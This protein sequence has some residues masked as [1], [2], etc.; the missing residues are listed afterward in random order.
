MSRLMPRALA[1]VL[2]TFIPVLSALLLGIASAAAH[3]HLTRAEPSVDSTVASPP[4]ELTLWFTENLES[5]FSSIEVTDAA[6]ARMD[7]G[8]P[9]IS[10]KVMH[11]GL[12]ALQPGAYKVQWRALSV[13][14]HKTDGTFMFQ[15]GK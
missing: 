8:Q 1:L 5:V 11:V 15:V 10:G 12:K 14:T 3:A 4:H 9:Q 2:K 6:G 13:D 7:E